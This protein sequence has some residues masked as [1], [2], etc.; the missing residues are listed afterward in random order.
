MHYSLKELYIV[1][2]QTKK[3]YIVSVR[4]HVFNTL[5][6]YSDHFYKKI[7]N[8]IVFRKHNEPNIN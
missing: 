6:L 7:R 5:A 3:Y 4:A 2:F 8:Y 1:H